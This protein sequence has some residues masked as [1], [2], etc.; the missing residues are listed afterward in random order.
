M[1]R[2]DFL[3]LVGGACAVSL[4]AHAQKLPS[5]GFLHSGD[6]GRF[7]E[8][9]DAFHQG[10]NQGGFVEGRNVAIEYRWA[11]NRVEQLR[12]LADDLVHKDVDVIFAGGGALP[13]LAAKAATSTIPI[14]FAYGGDPVAYGLVSSWN[15]PGG[16][17]TGTTFM[18]G[19]LASKRFELLAELVP[20]AKTIAYIFD[21]RAVT[22]AQETQKTIAAARAFKRDVLPM[23]VRSPTDL[24]PVVAAFEQGRAH[25]LFV[26]PFP[27]F[28]AYRE[29]ILKLA[30]RHKVPALYPDSIFV[31]N[32]GLMSYGASTRENFRQGGDFVARIL[33][34]ARPADTP[35]QQLTKIELVVNVRTV[36][37]LGL[38][39]PRMIR[40][41]ID[42]LVE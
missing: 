41:R 22:A 34:G 10:L 27:V 39:I 23:G 13:P 15:R 35:V 29:D 28:Y 6:R 19:E 9:L 3:I 2:R 14:V 30:E 4:G 40:P 20:M 25:A 7:L 11:G 1:I 36:K 8:M 21:P 38:T 12:A 18:T 26:G 32:G 33:N 5:V 24:E 42:E 37:A 16:N 17:I 31:L